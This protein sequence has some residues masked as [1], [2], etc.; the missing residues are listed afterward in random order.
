MV[1]K[2]ERLLPPGTR[3]R[4]LLASAYLLLEDV[5]LRLLAARS[6]EESRVVPTG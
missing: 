2:R 4:C 1:E 6:W 5:R 3:E